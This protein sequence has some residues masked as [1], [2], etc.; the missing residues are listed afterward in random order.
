MQFIRSHLMKKV[1]IL[2]SVELVLI[3]DYAMIEITDLSLNHAEDQIGTYIQTIISKAIEARASDIHFEPRSS[4]YHIRFRIDGVLY[5]ITKIA[6]E[7]AIRLS[8]R[9]KIMGQLD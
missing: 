7:L 3:L 2:S 4:E 8:T 5:P 9:L 6:M 1:V